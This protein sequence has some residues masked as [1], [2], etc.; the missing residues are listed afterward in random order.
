MPP[1]RVVLFA[2]TI[3]GIGFAVRAAIVGAPPLWACV[4]ATVAYATIITVG[5][6]ILRL[7]MF[8]DAVIRG[9]E[10]AKGVALT[11][12]DGPHPV[13]TRKILDI[14]DARAAKATFFVIGR[15]AKEH[16]DVVEEILARG[17]AIGVHGY[18]HDRLFSLRGASRV[19]ADLVQAIDLL[20]EIAGERPTLFRPP[21]GHTNPTIARVAAELDLEVIGW[22]VAARDGVAGTKPDDVVRRIGAGIEDGAILL[23]HDAA[24]NDDREPACV[25]ALP[26]VLDAIDAQ[27]LRVTGLEDFL[28]REPEAATR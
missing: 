24:E 19:R 10:G 14:L 13:H 3:A 23:L 11:F 26:R 25:A 27:N 2:S 4:A 21:I 17:H 7:R 9:G 18:A 5:V 28:E 20:T 1:A 16:R 6:L 22:S 8:T 15:K 12:D